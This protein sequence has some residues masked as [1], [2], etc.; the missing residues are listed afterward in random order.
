MKVILLQD[1]KNV[2]KKGEIKE[3][4]DGYGMNFLIKRKLAVPA[5]QKAM[6]VK[7]EEDLEAKQRYEENKAKAIEMKTYLE[8]LT[9]TIYTKGGKEGKMFGNISTK[10]IVEEYRKQ[11]NVS[12]DKRKFIDVNPI[13]S[14]GTSR[15]KMELFKDVIATLNVQVLEK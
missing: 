11:F 2:G 9:L 13:A 8:S 1:V 14:F 12:L 10:Q 7:R 4:S 3:V 6:E 5:T 15:L